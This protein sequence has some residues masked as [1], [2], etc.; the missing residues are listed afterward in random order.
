MRIRYVPTSSG[1]FAVQVVSK[2][3]G[4]LTVHK[5]IG[6]YA[7]RSEKLLLCQ[8]ARDFIQ[9]A[10]GQSS[11]LDLAESVRP[12]NI[13]VSENLPLFVYRVLTAVYNRLGLN[14]C[15]DPLI[16]DLVVARVYAPASKRETQEVL[17]DL[18]DRKYSLKT[19]YRHLKTGIQSG[20]KD[21]FQAA[22]IAFARDGLGDSLR[23]VFYDVTTL[24]FESTARSGIRDFGFSKDHRPTQTQI[25]VGLVVNPRGFPLYFD[26]FTGRTFEGH[27]FLPVVQNICWLLGNPKLVVIADAAMISQ[28]NIDQLAQNHIGFVV[29]A[30][31]ANLP[32]DL[33]GTIFRRLNRRDGKT[34][35]VTYHNQRLICQYLDSRASQDKS[36]RLRQI[37]RAEA[38]VSSPSKL[39]GRYRFVAASGQKYS[40]NSGLITKAEKLEGIKGYLTNTALSKTVVINRYHDLWRIEKSFRIT[41]SDL[42]ARP[43]FHRLDETI[44]AHLVIVFAGL[45]VSKYIEISTG[46]SV[47]KVLKLAGKVLTHKITNTQTGETAYTETTIE[48]L[49]LRSKIDALRTLGH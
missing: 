25:V 20:L 37:T 10:S 43:I 11:L 1:K 23:L 48:D 18:F 15:P 16:R 36:D 46:M 27:T 4:K 2:L 19:V 5:H 28:A 21:T 9:K 26:V 49:T 31:M 32:V 6:T 34:T 12:F 40:L 24:Y 41:K 22:L 29:G 17:A 30:R 7:D 3:H 47:Q 44:K 13:A 38:A 14:K 39:T 35:T 45:A 8:T 33:L 42:E